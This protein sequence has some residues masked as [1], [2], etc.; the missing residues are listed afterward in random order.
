MTSASKLI[1]TTYIMMFCLFLC[2][3]NKKNPGVKIDGPKVR[4][5]IVF[6]RAHYHLWQLIHQGYR[7]V[8]FKASHIF[9]IGLPRGRQK[10]WCV[11]FSIKNEIDWIFPCVDVAM[12]WCLLV[13]WMCPDAG[14]YISRGGMMALG[15]DTIQ[16]MDEECLLPLFDLISK[17]IL[18]FNI[19]QFSS[20]LFT[21]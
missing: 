8:L 2:S 18:A 7:E 16:S 20:N 14:F 6:R 15:L 1:P 17:H 13:D 9:W 12:I 21:R 5:T 3:V 11:F 10:N 19:S 4:G